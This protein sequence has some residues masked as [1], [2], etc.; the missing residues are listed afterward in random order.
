MS[1]ASSTHHSMLQVTPGAR[2]GLQYVAW[3]RSMRQTAPVWREPS[4]GV[5]NVFCYDDAAAVMQ[6]H[7]TFSS[8]RSGVPMFQGDIINLDPPRHDQLRGLVSQ[9]FTPR[10][11]AQLEPRV[12]VITTELLEYTHGTTD[13]ELIDALAYPLPVTV[14]AEM[15]G[16]PAADRPLFKQWTD[17]LHRITD[18]ELASESS[19]RDAAALMRQFHDYL[20][21][22]V[23]ARRAQPREDLLSGLASAELEGQRLS[24]EEIVGFAT[25]LLIAGH[26]TTTSALANALLCL[27]EHPEAQAALRAEPSK[28]PVAIE[29]VLRFR[30]PVTRVERVATR[31]VAL[32][33]QQIPRGE[34]VH[35]WL[36]SANRDERVFPNADD[37]VFERHPNRHLAFASGIHF[38]LGA[39]LARLELLCALD[40]LLRRFSQI[41]V[42]PAQPPTAYPTPLFNGVEQL[43]LLVEH[44]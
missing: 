28:L 17:Q 44:A 11:I 16:V 41:R 35:V 40:I 20:L 2:P 22:H 42:D 3:F 6:E 27:D 26:V 15:L 4:S 37:F 39:P 30:S 32:R 24:D 21:E 19:R 34:E 7:Q 23:R 13:V 36:P 43:H 10:A 9:V 33:G 14:I 5:W 31:D 38:C 12:R 25:I 18:I 8:E 29:E 1:S